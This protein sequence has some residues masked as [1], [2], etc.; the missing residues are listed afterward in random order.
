MNVYLYVVVAQDVL[1][2]YSPAVQA[3]LQRL[4]DRVNLQVVHGKAIGGPDQGDP[5]GALRAVSVAHGS[6][7]VAGSK[8]SVV[9]ESLIIG[10]AFVVIRRYSFSVQCRTGRSCRRWSTSSA[11]QRVTT[12]WC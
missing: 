10:K 2:M 6:I 5:L 1:R 8:A 12:T 7:I 3:D 4:H 11:V 9:S